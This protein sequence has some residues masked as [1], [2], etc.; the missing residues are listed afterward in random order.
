MNYSTKLS[1]NQNMKCKSMKLIREYLHELKVDGKD[2]VNRTQST[3][4][5]NNK[6]LKLCYIKNKAFK[7][8]K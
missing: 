4:T 8:S 3:L 7:S 2:F 1:Y 6:I 5:I